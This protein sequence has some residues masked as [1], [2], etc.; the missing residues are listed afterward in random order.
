MTFP[1]EAL[2]LIFSHMEDDL[3]LEACGLVWSDGSIT[4]LINQARSETR[5]AVSQTLLAEELA[6]VDVDEKLMVAFYHSHPRGLLELSNEDHASFKD[7]SSYVNL[8]WLIVTSDRRAR[9]FV[10]SSLHQSPMSEELEVPA[11]A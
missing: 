6:Q 2:E 11:N 10:W 7:Q 5:F 4:R 1:T 9:I 8:P 3:P